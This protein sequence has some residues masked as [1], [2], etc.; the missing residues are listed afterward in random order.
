VQPRIKGEGIRQFAKWYVDRWG[1]HRLAEHVSA[2]PADVRDSFDPRSPSLGVI[3]SQWYPARALHLLI[4]RML[5]DYDAEQRR[6][7]ARAAAKATL[8]ASLRGVYKL[9]FDLFMTPDRYAA[10]AQELFD[11]FYDRG[12][13]EKI[14]VAPTVHRTVIHD[15]PAH[16]PVL[17][18][19]MLHTSEYVY[20]ALGCKN[21]IVQRLG[22][23][24]AGDASC[25]YEVRWG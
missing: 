8:D 19:V 2:L 7:F 5:T 3:S 14:V 9:L 1:E 15:W 4:D 12:K 22:C 11:R 16:H 10:R 6:T 25:S 13:L 21:V 18:D 24:S 17:C 23:V 20:P